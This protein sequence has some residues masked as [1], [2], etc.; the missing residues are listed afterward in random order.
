MTFN[1]SLTGTLIPRPLHT[2][3]QD[4]PQ[5]LASCCPLKDILLPGAPPS[6][7]LGPLLK[8]QIP[9]LPS[10]PSNLNPGPSSPSSLN[11]HVP[12]LWDPNSEYPRLRAPHIPGARVPQAQVPPTAQAGEFFKSRTLTPPSLGS[13]TT[14]ARGSY[15]LGTPAPRGKRV[16]QAQVPPNSERAGSSG[17][18]PPRLPVFKSFRPCP[19]LPH[20]HPPTLRRL[21]HIPRGLTRA[22]QCG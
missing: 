19:L 13:P 9:Q 20:P 8:S 10:P 4:P 7:S 15:R 22:G 1:S 16:P 18:K 21:A 6:L 14:T 5:N 17:P 2:F 11:N 3:L 12:R